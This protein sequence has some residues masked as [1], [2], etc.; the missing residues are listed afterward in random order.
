MLTRLTRFHA[1]QKL[2]DW[3]MDRRSAHVVVRWTSIVI[4]TGGQ[5]DRPYLIRA[6]W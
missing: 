3:K 6:R 2:E 5:L 1:H 4:G